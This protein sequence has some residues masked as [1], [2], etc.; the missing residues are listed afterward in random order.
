M[1]RRGDVAALAIALAV[2]GCGLRHLAR[3]VGEGRGELRASVG[4]PILG[5]A[6]V[7][8]PIPS[9]RLGG[10]YGA[11]DWL[12]VDGNLTV[13]AFAVGV[14]AFDAGLVAQLY[15]DAAFAMSLSAHGHLL[16][17]LNDDAT[18][19]GFPELGLH[20][21]HR[22]APWLTVYGGAVAL[23]Q[24]DP[25]LDKPP[26]FAAP[27]LGFELVPDPN[28]PTREGIVF[29]IA[30]ISP[31]EDFSSFAAWEPRGAGAIVVNLGWRAIY[32]PG[33]APEVR[34]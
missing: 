18:T 27:Y 11:T 12:D 8:F 16:V 28:P 14:W 15:R 32:G 33:E 26:V 3:T 29:Q 17:D 24:L 5:A 4:G 1:V 30:W 23:A 13:D 31:W 22:L 6:P 34:P 19:H 25:P 21:E 7:S 20:V 9:A 10:R 2:S